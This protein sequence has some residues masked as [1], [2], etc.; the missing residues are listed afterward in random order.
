MDSINAV[1]IDPESGFTVED[2]GVRPAHCI[3]EPPPPFKYHPGDVTQWYDVNGV[4]KDVETLE[5]IRSA[6]ELTHRVR[7]GP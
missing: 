4:P 3:S 5:E 2:Y 1:L 7:L 6:A